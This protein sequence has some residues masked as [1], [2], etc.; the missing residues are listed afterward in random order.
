MLAGE[1]HRD[2]ARPAGGDIGAWAV[3]GGGVHEAHHAAG[4]GVDGDGDLF[5]VER[6]E[7]ARG[8][9]LHGSIALEER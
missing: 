7:V 6:L 1:L 9:V 8:P 2:I 3:F 5:L 4:L